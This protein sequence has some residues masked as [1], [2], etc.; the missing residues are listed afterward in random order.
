MVT[1]HV[2]SYMRRDAVPGFFRELGREVVKKDSL[3]KVFVEDN[4]LK[5]FM[6]Q[7]LDVANAEYVRREMASSTKDN[8]FDVDAWVIV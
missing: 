7:Q 1:K 2:L 4:R 6:V 3:L 8:P 5:S